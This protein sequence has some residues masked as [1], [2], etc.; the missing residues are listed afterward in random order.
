MTSGYNNVSGEG[1]DLLPRPGDR[2]P[3]AAKPFMTTG[4]DLVH[5]PGRQSADE[6]PRPDQR[7]H[8]GLPQ[9]VRRA[10]LRR[11]P[12]RKLVALRRQRSESGELDGANKFAT[13]SDGGEPATGHDRRRRSRSISTTAS[14]ATSLSAP[15]RLLDASDLTT[16]ATAQQQTLYAIRDGSLTKPL[17]APPRRACCPSMRAASSTPVARERR[18]ASGRARPTAGSTT[19][20]S[21]PTPSGSSSTSRPT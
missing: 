14:T 1:P 8:Q 13:L 7:L 20:P 4:A 6:R 21:G 16:P 19:C 3:I 9:P 18:G 17:P 11:R 15:G 10:D 12:L 5:R 2:R